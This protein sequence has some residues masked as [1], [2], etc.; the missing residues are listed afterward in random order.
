MELLETQPGGPMGGSPCSTAAAP[1]P[2]A[3]LAWRLKEEL[4]QRHCFSMFFKA[5]PTTF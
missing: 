1:A 5:L 3:P 2:C 4:P